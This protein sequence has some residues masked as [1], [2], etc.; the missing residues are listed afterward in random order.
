LT[1]SLAGRCTGAMGGVIATSSPAVGARCLYARAEVGVVLTQNRT[2]PRLGPRGL[3]LLADGCSPAA[4]LAALLASTPHAGWRQLAVLDR[5]G[6][7]AHHSGHNIRS[8]HQGVI[9][10]NC[11]AAGNILRTDAVPGAMVRAFE[12]AEGDDLPARLLAALEAGDAAGGEVLSLRSSALLV[13]WEEAFPYA[14]LR[15]DAAPN[16]IAALRAL[17]DEYAPHADDY[18]RRAL[19]PDSCGPPAS[20]S[21]FRAVWCGSNTLVDQIKATLGHPLSAVQ[22]GDWAGTRTHPTGQRL[23]TVPRQRSPE[24]PTRVGHVLHRPQPAHI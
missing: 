22:A 1:F 24:R 13:V 4:T 19:D 14:D 12:D 11:V 15:V 9:G 10:R 5:I 7:A 8:R 20:Y 17:W 23:P 16:P 21:T 2:D 18:V 3:R 6:E